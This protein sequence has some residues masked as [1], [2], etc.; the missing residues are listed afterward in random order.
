MRTTKSSTAKTKSFSLMRVSVEM[1]QSSSW[2]IFCALCFH[3]HNWCL[4][5]TGTYRG[6]LTPATAF[7]KGESLTRDY[8]DTRSEPPPARYRY[9]VVWDI[10]AFSHVRN[11]RLGITDVFTFFFLFSRFFPRRSFLWKNKIFSP[12]ITNFA[13]AFT[14]RKLT[15]YSIFFHFVHFCLA[16]WFKLKQCVRNWFHFCCLLV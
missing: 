8:S 12:H 4:S 9:A 11:L 16:K 2:Q 7:P 5:R 13:T 15:L 1:S 3:P 10:V 14:Y 6:W